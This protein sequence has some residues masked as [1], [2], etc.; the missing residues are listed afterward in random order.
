[1]TH[2][3]VECAAIIRRELGEPAPRIIALCGGGNNGGDGY[4]LIRTLH[5]HDISAIAIECAAPA[6]GSDAKIMHDAAEKMGLVRP[7]NELPSIARDLQP[8]LIIDAIIGT[9]LSH[10]PSSHAL[11]AI[12]WI[13][14]RRAAGARVVAIDL[15]SGMDCDS[16]EPLGGANDVVRATD[17][18]TMVCEKAGFARPAAKAYLG[19]LKIVSIGGPPPT[20]DFQIVE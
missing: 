3:A 1:M 9:G 8:L 10:S 14:A 16:G 7:M 19:A 20:Q 17:T 11:E 18:I 12:H 15:P 4:A 6:T 5:S 13:N 2:A